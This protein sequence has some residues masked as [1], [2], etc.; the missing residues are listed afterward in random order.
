MCKNIKQAARAVLPRY[1]YKIKDSEY[2][3]KAHP[4]LNP[5]QNIMQHPNLKLRQLQ[6]PQIRLIQ[7][8]LPRLA[9]RTT[10]LRHLLVRTETQEMQNGTELVHAAVGEAGGDGCGNAVVRMLEAARAVALGQLVQ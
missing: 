7:K 4:E 10:H 8:L 5:L 1:R 2:A 6:P 3:P 9:T